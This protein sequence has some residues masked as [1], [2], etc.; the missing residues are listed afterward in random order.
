MKVSFSQPVD[1]RIAALGCGEVARVLVGLDV[2]VDRQRLAGA[3]RRVVGERLDRDARL[4]GVGYAA[5]V[6]QA[7]AAGRVARASLWRKRSPLWL[8]S[9]GKPQM[10]RLAL[11]ERRQLGDVGDGEA[12]AV[13]GAGADR[14]RDRDRDVQGRDDELRAA[15]SGP[16]GADVV[17]R[18]GPEQEVRVA[19]VVGVDGDQADLGVRRALVEREVRPACS[20]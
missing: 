3:G 14:D 1:R 19:F 10:V 12:E 16:P 15:P 6:G 5:R 18:R 11:G 9:A 13:V 8:R 2:E 20:W 17:D 7:R 4:V